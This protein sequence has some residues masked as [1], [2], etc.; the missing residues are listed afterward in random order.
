MRICV[1]PGHG[2]AH[3]GAVA[4]SGLREAD[5]VLDIGL[6]LAA[7]LAT[8][9][10][11]VTVTRC[12]DVT[13]EL[14]E[15]CRLANAVHAELFVSVHANAVA[16]ERAHGYEV[17]TSRGETAADPAATAVFDA[18]H[19]AFPGLR[20]RADYYDGDPDKEANFRVL[21]GTLM[22]AVLVE[23]AFLSHP[24]EA[25]FLAQTQWRRQMAHAIADGVCAWCEARH[26]RG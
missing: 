20:A 16:D 19:Q 10:H 24:T 9:G 3:P 23:V 6:H 2:G 8:R 12:D 14:D 13:V 21:V 5:V 4:A 11:D 7:I 25:G 17:W 18:I 22:P 1:D 26:D 15:R